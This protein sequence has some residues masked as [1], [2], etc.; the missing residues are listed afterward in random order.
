MGMSLPSHVFANETP[1][2]FNEVRLL[3][4]ENEC[5]SEEAAQT[6][7]CL[8]EYAKLTAYV[9]GV[10]PNLIT[11]EAR[12][13]SP[14]EGFTNT[15][16][17]LQEEVS[18]ASTELT[19][20]EEDQKHVK[21]S[22]GKQFACNLGR[23]VISLVD[24]MAPEFLVNKVRRGISSFLSPEEG[25]SCLDE[26]SPDCLTEVY[27]SFVGSI[28]ATVTSFRDLGRVTWGAVTG[29]KDYLFS[30]SEDL[31]EAAE[32]TQDEAGSF[33][34]NPG[35]YI[36]TKLTNI[37]TSIDS[38]IKDTVF[39]QKW[40]TNEESGEK[41]CTEPLKGYACLDCNDGINAFCAGAGFVLSEGLITVATAGTLTG[42]GVMARAGVHLAEGLAVKG[43]AAIAQRVP[44]IGRLAQRGGTQ[45]R[46]V[47]IASRT[48]SLVNKTKEKLAHFATL[49]KSSAPGR[50]ITKVNE[51]ATMPLRFVDNLSQK[52]IEKVLAGATRVR[53]TNAVSRAIRE[54]A[55]AD[56]RAIR[57]AARTEDISTGAGT[58]TRGV[59]GAK[60]IRVGNRHRTS[61]RPRQRDPDRPVPS[62]DPAR[63]HN[64][65]PNRDRPT[66]PEDPRTSRDDSGQNRDGKRSEDPRNAGD[67]RDQ[68]DRDQRERE[69]SDDSSGSSLPLISSTA[70]VTK[71][72][73]ATDLAVKSVR[74][75]NDDFHEDL[76][77]SDEI[78]QAELAGESVGIDESKSLSDNL[79]KRT[80]QRFESEAQ[81]RQFTRNMNSVY[82]DPSRRNEVLKK[83][84]ERRGLSESEAQR[85]FDS[86]KNF[87]SA[88][89][90]RLAERK[91]RTS[92]L[93][94]EVQ[95]LKKQIKISD[96]ASKVQGLRDELE[97]P[98]RPEASP[99]PEQQR[100]RQEQ[101]RLPSDQQRFSSSVVGP[102][103]SPTAF[104]GGQ[105]SP[106]S[107]NGGEISASEGFS[108]SPD[109][110]ENEVG[111]VSDDSLVP[112]GE[113]SEDKPEDGKIAASDDP[114]VTPEKKEEREE[115]PN[116]ARLDTM[117]FFS[118]FLN[119]LQDNGLE[120]RSLT[121]GDL[122][123]FQK[124]SQ[125]IPQ[126][127]ELSHTKVANISD[128]SRQFSLFYDEKNHVSI[129]LDS[130][131]NYLSQIPTDLME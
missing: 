112:E 32:T 106:G 50:A 21:E 105:R 82:S 4:F 52:S 15:I 126:A 78:V 35:K 125:Q 85:V 77:P 14:E 3:A 86:E 22:C 46:K 96:L 12:C 56:F 81:A 13:S 19:C 123:A 66:P 24:S 64:R 43:A 30:K 17:T 54:T 55:K 124:A 91:R 75:I 40:G 72:V 7:H 23:S 27:R 37:R 68:R 92:N 98:A 67:T 2:D 25:S 62:H 59:M 69:K 47:G 99:T 11:P 120:F 18:E 102:T 100:R 95:N 8:D 74:A 88:A 44:A 65:D 36:M 39:C 109:S 111:S 71:A 48:V 83:I 61:N 80:G 42:V 87:Y 108:E 34:E 116:A 93:L 58:A 10:D 9:E 29:L 117:D 63:D 73:V 94:G 16:A 33:M 6:A 103:P 97:V 57:V 127:V 38:W 107:F 51:I 26:D 129:V 122:T 79:E 20:N 114:E 41:E 31:H 101:Q 5:M 49:L 128:G 76:V 119:Q 113:P 60:V 115:G 84:M 28:V 121:N 70:S 53:G 131:G 1:E 89:T 104:G 45:A 90:E 110:V 130:Q 118:L